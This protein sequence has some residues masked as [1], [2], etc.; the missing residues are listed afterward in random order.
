MIFGDRG[1]LSSAILGG[2]ILSERKGSAQDLASDGCGWVKGPAFGKGGAGTAADQSIPKCFQNIDQSSTSAKN[3]R[4][5]AY[6]SIFFNELA[7][8]SSWP[9][10]TPGCPV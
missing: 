2:L 10:L 9:G 8:L 7:F 3:T 1:R 5:R 4:A 6:L